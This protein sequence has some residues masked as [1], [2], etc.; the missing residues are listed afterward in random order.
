MESDHLHQYRF[1]IDSDVYWIH[2]DG[3]LAQS[4]YKII[5]EAK[6]YAISMQSPHS[7]LKTLKRILS[8]FQTSKSVKESEVSSSITHLLTDLL[9]GKPTTNRKISSPQMIERSLAYINFF[10]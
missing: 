5:T 10:I 1:P 8:I 7:S 3:P 9:Y 4:Y 2:F 6:G